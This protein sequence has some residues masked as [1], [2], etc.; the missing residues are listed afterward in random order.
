MNKLSSPSTGLAVGKYFRVS[1]IDEDGRAVLEA[2]DLP[3]ATKTSVGVGYFN[4]DNGVGINSVT[5]A[6]YTSTAYESQI[7]GKRDVR[8]PITPAYLD[9]AIRAGLLSNSQITDAD[10]GQICQTIG[11]EPKKGEWVLKGTIAGDET[12]RG[13]IDTRLLVDMTGCTEIIIEGWI[14]ATNNVL[15]SMLPP[16]SGIVNGIGVNG[17]RYSKTYIIETGNGMSTLYSKSS[18]AKEPSYI[19]NVLTTYDY[20]NIKPSDITAFVFEGPYRTNVVSCDLKI[21]AR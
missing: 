20:I 3:I 14:V 17:T 10:K 9:Y 13:N 11:A 8:R 12:N 21:Y 4:D 16:Q 5:G 2:V 7:N 19:T 1:A 15:L 18:N 6:V